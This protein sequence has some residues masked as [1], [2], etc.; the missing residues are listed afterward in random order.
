MTTAVT[1]N[2]HQ[3]IRE[4]RTQSDLQEGKHLVT[5]PLTSAQFLGVASSQCGLPKICTAPRS[6]LV[7]SSRWR[8]RGEG[9]KWA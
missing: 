2:L 5:T 6:V 7:D 1:T 8:G 4:K 3:A 9:K